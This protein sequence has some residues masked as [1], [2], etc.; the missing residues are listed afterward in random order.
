M[1]TFSISL[2]GQWKDAY[3][4]TGLEVGSPLL[5]YVDGGSIACCVS[6]AQPGNLEYGAEARQGEQISVGD[7]S[8]N[9]V[10]LRATSGG[11]AVVRVQDG[12]PW[13]VRKADWSDKRVLDGGKALTTQDIEYH[14]TKQGREYTAAL[15][16]DQFL[17]GASLDVVMEI[18]DSWGVVIK[19]ISAQFNTG[20][21]SSQVF[22]SPQYTG[23]ES[24]P[25]YNLRDEVA[26]ADDVVVLS[27]L[28]VT[29]SGTPVSPKVYSIGTPQQGSKSSSSVSG[30]QRVERILQKGAN[31]LFR[32]TN[33]NGDAGALAA[34]AVWYQGPLTTE[35]P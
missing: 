31:Y 23:G 25:V 21:I 5:V 16:T 8:S 32:F 17:A 3:L 24:V 18:G 6:S 22:K 12:Q 35:L 34:D 13:S 4:E 30:E 28:T 33:E 26:V 7:G 10:W 2:T 29:D 9:S 11:A 15:Y 19:T 1:G 14:H 20:L 27:G